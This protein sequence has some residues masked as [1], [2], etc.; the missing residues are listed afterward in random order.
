MCVHRPAGGGFSAGAYLREG[1]RCGGNSVR[2]KGASSAEPFLAT[3]TWYHWK[4]RKEK[5]QKKKE[6][7]SAGSRVWCENDR[8]SWDLR[9]SCRRSCVHWLFCLGRSLVYLTCEGSLGGSQGPAW[10]RRLRGEE[11][12][13]RRGQSADRFS[14][15]PLVP[16]GTAPTSLGSQWE[17]GHTHARTHT[18]THT[19]RHAHTHRKQK[20]YL[21]LNPTTWKLGCSF[22]HYK[23]T[24][25][26]GRGSG[27]EWVL[28]LA[29]R[30]LGSALRASWNLS[31]HH[32]RF[33]NLSANRGWSQRPLGPEDAFFILKFTWVFFS[34]IS[35][36]C[37]NHCRKTTTF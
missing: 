20:I 17:G 13:P 19:N 3:T 15:F 33:R 1:I 23:H 28:C 30:Y 10:T 8:W 27:G 2:E 6:W 22:Y 31:C 11:G 9:K 16:P 24:H 36:N 12:A 7:E 25:G 4:K 34:N 18:R 21:F 26:Y 14:G 35:K 29:R 5:N 37:V 32:N